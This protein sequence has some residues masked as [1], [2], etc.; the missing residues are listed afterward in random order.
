M[1]VIAGKAKSLPLK[2]IEGMN[3]R[4]TTDRIKETLFNM[5]GAWIPGC[6]FLD[7][8]A[9]SG[10]I[11]IEALSRGAAEA[12]FVEQNRKAAAVIR[13]NLA[14]TRLDGR[15]RVMER[16]VLTAVEE[17]SRRGC[18]FDVIFMDPPYDHLWEKKVLE[19]MARTPVLAPEGQIIV[20]ASLDT[21][22]A[23]AES[24]G[25][26]IVRVKTYKTNQHVFLRKMTDSV[27]FS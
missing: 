22:F 15:A 21:G 14:F 16:D 4:P 10:G 1:R 8:F 13:E 6:R 7:L 26:E 24:L 11:G 2:T 12:V 5:I 20:E 18:T 19:A 23:Y 25:F 3:T 9:G 27:L 17:L